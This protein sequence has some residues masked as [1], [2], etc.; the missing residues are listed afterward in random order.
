MGGSEEGREG[1]REEGRKE[2]KEGG[3]EDNLAVAWL[4]LM[5]CTSAHPFKKF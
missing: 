1:R 2:G 5:I 4:P 3:R